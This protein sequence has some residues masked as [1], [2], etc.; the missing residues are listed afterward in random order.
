MVFSSFKWDGPDSSVM[1]QRDREGYKKAAS[2]GRKTEQR[3]KRGN[4][5]YKKQWFRLM[6]EK[7]NLDFGIQIWIFEAFRA[8]KLSLKNSETECILIKRP[9]WKIDTPSLFW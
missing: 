7:G 8:P 5:D 9:K 6:S 2:Q 4:R 1:N 3:D